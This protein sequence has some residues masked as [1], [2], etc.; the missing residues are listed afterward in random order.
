VRGVDPLA[1]RVGV[2]DGDKDGAAGRG[3]SVEFVERGLLVVEVLEDV[4]G[5]NVLEAVVA[6][7]PWVVVEINDLVW[8]NARADV[9][10]VV[11]TPVVIT[12]TQVQSVGSGEA[13]D[14]VDHWLPSDC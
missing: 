5:V 11:A 10:V 3:D 6:P 13:R 4:A 12:A 9:D 14:S 2:G 1:A 8:G 7:R